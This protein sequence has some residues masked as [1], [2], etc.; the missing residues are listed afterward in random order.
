MEEFPANAGLSRSQPTDEEFRALVYALD[1]TPD[2][3]I[4]DVDDAP[5]GVWVRSF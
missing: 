2:A 1:E 3:D 4:T 5:A